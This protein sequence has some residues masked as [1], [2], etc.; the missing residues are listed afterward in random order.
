MWSGALPRGQEGRL[1]PGKT[2]RA[3]PGVP[4]EKMLPG[5]ILVLMPTLPDL[6]GAWPQK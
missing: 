6:E 1:G 5:S 4:Q 3:A 2:G